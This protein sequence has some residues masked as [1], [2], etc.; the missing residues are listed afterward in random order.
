MLGAQQTPQGG[1]RSPPPSFHSLLLKKNLS[2]CSSIVLHFVLTKSFFE[3]QAQVVSTFIGS[4]ETAAEIPGGG[5]NA[6]AWRVAG[7]SGS[8][9]KN[10]QGS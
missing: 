4:S 6:L 8:R 2:I 5:A 9:P 10:E 1:W 3:G 7:P